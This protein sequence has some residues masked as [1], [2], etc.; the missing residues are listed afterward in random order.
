M[1][2]TA[3]SAINITQGQC[4]DLFTSK[5][6]INGIEMYTNP[7]TNNK[8]KASGKV[9]QKLKLACDSISQSTTASRSTT[10]NNIIKRWIQ[11]PLLDPENNNTLSINWFDK[12]DRYFSLYNQAYNE[13]I[14][15]MR[16]IEAQNKLP[17]KHCIFGF[18]LYWYENFSIDKQTKEQYQI[19]Y[20]L[21]YNPQ[22]YKIVEEIYNNLIIRKKLLINIFEL[23][24]LNKEE[25]FFLIFLCREISDPI[26]YYIILSNEILF[27]ERNDIKSLNMYLPAIQNMIDVC[28]NY[29]TYYDNSDID[30]YLLPMM[31]ERI[32]RVPLIEMQRQNYNIKN[33]ITF[34]KIEDM[35]LRS[36][37]MF[38][39]MREKYEE[40][41]KI[42]NWENNSTESPF[43]NIE[44]KTVEKIE[45]PL[46]KILRDI[47]IDNIDTDNLELKQRIFQS[48]REYEDFKKEYQKLNKIYQEE[49]NKWNQNSK[50]GSPP[51][52]PI[53]K[54]P[55]DATLNITVSKLPQH[56]NDAD[57]NS[58]KE[59]YEKRKPAIDMY[60][61][62]LNTGIKEL[63][64]KYAKNQTIS[65][66]TH[67]LLDKNRDYFQKNIF[68]IG[69]SDKFKCNSNTDAIGQDE[70]DDDN[71]LLSRLQLMF[72]L[73][74][75]DKNN[76]IIRTDCFYAPN[77]YNYIVTK[78]QN[79]S[80]ITN[81]LTNQ[82]VS[83]EDIERLM[84]IMRILVPDIEY[85]NK[86]K[87]P[88]DKQLVIEHEYFRTQVNGSFY[89][90]SI[91]RYLGGMKILIADV[92]LIPADFEVRETGSADISS[93]IF[94]FSLYK[95]FN[96]G[97]LLL[98][99][100]P[101]Y[102][103]YSDGSERLFKIPVNFKN[104]SKESQWSM[105]RTRKLDIFKS[106]L[107]DI[108]QYL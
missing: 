8:I 9:F 102:K 81:P 34:E 19:L 75:R 70:F 28:E 30:E 99:Y 74:T 73:Y 55:N 49:W 17:K 41:F 95:L 66:E 71:Y 5:E 52:R 13:L 11:K 100:L 104:I 80:I 67:E 27:D 1:S 72:Q 7:L 60:K 59:S 64:E 14:K 24:D 77:F 105:T 63:L 106:Y 26:M 39:F 16:P 37:N 32:G 69:N 10:G 82:K 40:L 29:G 83:E 46:L 44:K 89:K 85:P 3:Y 103:D 47:G 78:V 87:H 94:V 90:V 65:E 33:K 21:F 57:Y 62:L 23:N 58:L 25:L 53:M 97:K 42:C 84:K 31:F 98:N 107:E 35:L 22:N 92:C 51:K 93:D 76:N 2:S 50:N 101:N 96:D 18:D 20:D 15:T 68:D 91:Y 43:Y 36:K 108:R 54:M 6:I 12:N 86:V 79:D 4:N 45:D 88:H 38:F 61:G 56:I 48:D